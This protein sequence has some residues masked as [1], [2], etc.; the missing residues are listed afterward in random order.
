MNNGQLSILNWLMS[1]CGSPSSMDKILEEHPYFHAA[2]LAK[3]IQQ[4]DNTPD[5][6]LNIIS[7]ESIL[8][9][10]RDILIHLYSDMV[11]TISKN[12]QKEISSKDK[13]TLESMISDIQHKLSN[14]NYEL[15]SNKPIHKPYSLE[16]KKTEEHKLSEK[17]MRKKELMEEF[18][19]KSPTMSRST[20]TFFNPSDSYSKPSIDADNIVSETL[21]IIY[22]KQGNIEKA[23]NTYLKLI[24]LY[25][26]KESYFHFKIKGLYQ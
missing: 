17:Q 1:G 22:T 13:I 8:F 18:I 26:E 21:A 2:V 19:K 25:P 16:V 9:P 7:S 6:F 24:E 5:G 10:K 15:V 14:I 12:K 4:S 20:A 11:V 3:I 23:K